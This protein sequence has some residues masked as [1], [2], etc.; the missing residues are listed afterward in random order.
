MNYQG[1]KKDKCLPHGKHPGGI[2]HTR[3]NLKVFDFCHLG[4]ISSLMP[5]EGWQINVPLIT[6][7][8]PRKPRD[9]KDGYEK[10][11]L[12]EAARKKNF[13]AVQHSA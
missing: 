8:I 9:C 12:P 11:G 4:I 3:L 7:S 2:P 5:P 1:L 6:M 10:T 13:S